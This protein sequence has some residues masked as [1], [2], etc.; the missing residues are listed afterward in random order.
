MALSSKPSPSQRSLERGTTFLL[1]AVA[2]YADSAGFLSLFGLFTAHVTGNLVTAGAALARK[3][4]EGTIAKLALIPVFMVAV[5]ATSLL[6]RG[7]RRRKVDPLGPLLAIMTGALGL[8]W[9]LGVF[10]VRWATSPDAG[11]VIAIAGA[12]VLALGVQ[13]ALMREV[14]ASLSPT[15]VMTGNLT[16]FTIDLVHVSLPPRQPDRETAEKSRSESVTRLAKFGLAL[17]GFVLGAAM[18]AWLTGAYGL[19]S[20]GVPTLIVGVLTVWTL[21]SPRGASSP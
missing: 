2:G 1:S 18:G 9:A 16:Q 14:A 13:N 12:G 20:L 6:A 15:T 19:I 17:S 11:A 7:L 4:P 3:T 21:S 8:F 10:A 5:A